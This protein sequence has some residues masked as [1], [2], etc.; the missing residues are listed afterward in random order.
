MSLQYKF[1]SVGEL[2]SYLKSRAI[3]CR[4][5]AQQRC[6]PRSHSHAALIA[7][8]VANEQIAAMIENSNLTV[9]NAG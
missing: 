1:Y 6:S 4:L 8:A 5:R 2:V 7:E 3:D 9:A